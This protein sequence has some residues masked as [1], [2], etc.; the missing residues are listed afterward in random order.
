MVF[1]LFSDVLNPGE[2]MWKRM[3]NKHLMAVLAVLPT[4]AVLLHLY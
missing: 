1:M 4:G 3:S 2:K